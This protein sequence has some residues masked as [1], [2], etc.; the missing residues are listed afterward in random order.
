MNTSTFF[1]AIIFLSIL[2]S[3]NLTDC[4]RA[5]KI[6]GG[7]SRRCGCCGGW[8][9]EVDKHSFLCDSIPNAIENFG[10]IENWEFPI[11]VYLN[12]RRAKKCPDTRIEII[13][14]RKK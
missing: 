4:D 10:P 6:V 1:G 8:R 11:P 13:C 7:D 9:I 3:N 12:Y 14:I 2:G 5:G